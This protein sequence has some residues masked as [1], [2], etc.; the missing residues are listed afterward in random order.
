MGGRGRPTWLLQWI[1]AAGVCTLFAADARAQ[2]IIVN[3][4][5]PP[6]EG[7]RGVV[8]EEPIVILNGPSPPLENDRGVVLDGPTV[9]D[10]PLPPVK[11]NSRA[12]LGGPIEM[13]EERG[14]DVPILKAPAQSVLGYV[15]L[16]A[17]ATAP[18]LTPLIARPPRARFSAYRRSIRSC[19]ARSRWPCRLPARRN[20]GR[21]FRAPVR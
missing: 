4:P 6:V 9:V 8:F 19:H 10:G 7:K 11:N 5:A 17:I 14:A 1:V 16:E 21:R 12:A 2:P 20:S 13:R 3:G 15:T 18:A